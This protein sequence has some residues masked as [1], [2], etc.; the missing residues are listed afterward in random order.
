MYVCRSNSIRFKLRKKQRTLK[1]QFYNFG[2]HTL[3][4]VDVSVVINIAERIVMSRG[5]DLVVV[6]IPRQHPASLADDKVELDFG[7]RLLVDHS[8]TRRWLCCS[9]CPL[10]IHS[11]TRRWLC[12]SLCCHVVGL[13]LGRV[14]ILVSFRDAVVALFCCYCCCSLKSGGGG[15]AWPCRFCHLPMETTFATAR[16]TA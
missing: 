14:V 1:C 2:A 9:L 4:H 13:R 6:K 3:R 7:R 15:G 8:K 5:L 12:C 11:K 16:G 10:V